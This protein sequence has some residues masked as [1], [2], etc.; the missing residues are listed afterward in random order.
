MIDRLNIPAT[1]ATCFSVIAISASV[2]VSAMDGSRGFSV[3]VSLSSAAV[4][5]LRPG[6]VSVWWS[7]ESTGSASAP[8]GMGTIR[9]WS[10]TVRLPGSGG[11]GA[12]TGRSVQI[13]RV[14]W[15]KGRAVQINVFSARLSSTDTLPGVQLFQDTVVVAQ[16]PSR[17][18]C[19]A[20]SSE[21]VDLRRPRVSCAMPRR[22]NSSHSWRVGGKMLQSFPPISFVRSQTFT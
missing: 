22:R 4:A 11:L 2:P 6:V 7:G 9:S 10:R 8:I 18:K 21:S 17:L 14:D 3:D 16:L 5:K 15:V 19:F 1:F 20:S 13:K 12:I